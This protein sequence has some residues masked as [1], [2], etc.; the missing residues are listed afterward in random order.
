MKKFIGVFRE[1]S[2]CAFSD[3]ID[4]KLLRESIDYIILT[5]IFEGIE[6]AKRNQKVQPKI[7]STT[8]S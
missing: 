3:V 5:E 6:M 7:S 4:G 8:R 2:V 1:E